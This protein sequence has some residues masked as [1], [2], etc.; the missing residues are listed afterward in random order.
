MC[1]PVVISYWPRPI[2]WACPS[3]FPRSLIPNPQYTKA[4]TLEA[5]NRDAGWR[6]RGKPQ[7]LNSGT[8]A[9]HRNKSRAPD[10]PLDLQ[11]AP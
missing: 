5:G 11:I 6:V 3:A 9:E 4:L 1:L 10:I 8:H 7:G 2:L